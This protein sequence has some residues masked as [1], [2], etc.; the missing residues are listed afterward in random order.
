MTTK[1]VIYWDIDGVF[2]AVPAAHNPKPQR[3][4]TGGWDDWNITAIKADG[5]TYNIG[6][7]NDMVATVNAL[8]AKDNVTSKWLTTWLDLAVT[9]FAPGVGLD[10]PWDVIG[11]D[12]FDHYSK[13]WWKLTAILKDVGMKDADTK[14]WWV[15]DDHD[16]RL[17]YMDK[18]MLAHAG[19]NLI[20]T[21]MLVGV[22]KKDLKD[23][24][25][26]V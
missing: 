12:V 9:N 8:S 26:N 16:I 19:V 18:A 2:N 24:L 5:P 21:N 10:G 11:A 25:D 4:G 1:H 23:I 3:A 6:Y 22:K 7:S 17:P 14:V 13:P 15:D 20:T